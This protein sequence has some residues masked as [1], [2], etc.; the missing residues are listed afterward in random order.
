MKRDNAQEFK[1]MLPMGGEAFGNDMFQ[2]IKIAPFAGDF[3]DKLA[4]LGGHCVGN[5][6]AR[7]LRP[8]DKL[9]QHQ[10][11]PSRRHGRGD[12]GRVQCG[13]QFAQRSNTRQKQWFPARL[14]QKS[15]AQASAG[16]AG[17]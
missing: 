6:H 12:S 8:S 14:A 11:A 2:I 16:T 5:M 17:G 3:I 10:F 7:M 13:W 1:R 9:G 4:K 15:V